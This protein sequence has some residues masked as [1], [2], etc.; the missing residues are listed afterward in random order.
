MEKIS[1]FYG[2]PFNP[3]DW[4]DIMAVVNKIESLSE[5]RDIWFQYTSCSVMLTVEQRDKTGTRLRKED[6]SFK[7]H[8]RFHKHSNRPISVNAMRRSILDIIEQFLT[9][10]Y[11]G[12]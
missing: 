10:Y 7:D 1:N 11:N 5:N 9:V 4:N 6:G 8:I 3:E 2:K 12:K